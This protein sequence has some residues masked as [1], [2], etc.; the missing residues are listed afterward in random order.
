[1]SQILGD[2]EGVICLVDDILVSGMTQEEHDHRLTAVLSRLQ[3]TGLTLNVDK[4]EINKRS[5]KFLRQL[6]DETG[7]RPDPDKVRAIQKMKPPM[8]V[9]ELRRFLGMI[10]QQSKFSPSLAEQTKPL[11]DL[12]SS[13]NQWSWGAVQQN[14][15]ESLQKSLSSDQVLALYNASHPTVLSADASSYGLVAVL[16]QKQPDGS[17]R[18][19]VYASRTLTETEQRYAQIEEEALAVTWACE[20]FQDC[21]LGTSFS[22]ETD[23]KPLVPLLSTKAL[24]VVP[25][26]VQRFRLRLMKF[27]FAI[28]H[29]PGKELHT[30]DTLSRAP[31][32]DE[33]ASS[34]ALRQE[35]NAFV[36]AAVTSLPATPERLQTIQDE[37]KND[38]ICQQLRKYCKEG[39]IDWSGP[40]KQYYHVKMELTIAEDLLMRGNRV[41][42]P[43]SMRADILE[44]LH[45]GHQGST[46]CRQRAKESVWWPGIRRD[47]DE[48]TSN[49]LICCKHRLQYPEPLLPSPLPNRPWQKVATDLFEWKKV[50][51]LLVVDYYSRYIEVAK[52]ISTSANSVITH[53]KSIFSRH[54]I[55]ETVISDN[56]HQYSAAAFEEFSKEY[57]FN[58]A[59]SSPKYPQANCTAKRAVKMVK[60]LLVKNQDPYMAMLAYRAT[61]LENGYSSAEMLMGRK[62]RTTLPQTAKQLEPSLPNTNKLREKEK[63]M[64]DRMKRNFDERHGAKKLTPLS[65]GDLVW[66]PEHEAGGTVMRESNTGSY[67]VQTDNSTFRRNRRDLILMPSEMV[68]ESRETDQSDPEPPAEM[69]ASQTPTDNGQVTTKSG[70]VS[71][72]PAK[73][74]A[75]LD[76]TN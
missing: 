40:V 53:L 50:D 8:T 22:V 21:L 51:Y 29:V 54:G 67:V 2:L 6:I 37:Q 75:K 36:N 24:D 63:K 65:P 71:K 9:S 3:K 46:K 33:D 17:L 45:A 12:L 76:S 4:C 25:I 32:H 70:R 19:I 34:E 43:A 55:P 56:G 49:C 16:R 10:N 11:R 47:I 68:T 42:V 35:V 60:Q 58:H 59:T 23:H 30:A 20:K 27:S 31:V 52:L 5:V 62:L 13:K 44:R 1:M 57:G 38:P 74:Y 7:V 39:K 41:V 61:P 69:G 48:K 73:L 72:P 66:I 15:F 26:R 64:R 28:T 14:A 18:P